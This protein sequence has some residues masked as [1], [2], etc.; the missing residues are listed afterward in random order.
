MTISLGVTRFPCV[1]ANVPYKG[2]L[3]WLGGAQ[4]E[5]SGNWHGC[6]LAP[7]IAPH[8][9]RNAADSARERRRALRTRPACCARRPSRHAR[10]SRSSTLA[11][12]SRSPTS[13]CSSSV[14]RAAADRSPARSQFTGAPRLLTDRLGRTPLGTTQMTSATATSASTATRPRRPTTSTS[15]HT[16]ARCSPRGTRAAPCAPA[17]APL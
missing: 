15:S 11:R 10:S 6:S 2:R 1:Q 14:R 3:N 8:D 17:R 4:S 13:S 5:G 9:T 7:C 16:A 12:R